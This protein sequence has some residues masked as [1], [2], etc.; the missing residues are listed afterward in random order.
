VRLWVSK[1]WFENN[2]LNLMFFLFGMQFAFW[3]KK[4]DGDL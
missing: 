4:I 1:G 2:I 3:G